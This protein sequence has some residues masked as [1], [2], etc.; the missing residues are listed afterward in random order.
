MKLE[1]DVRRKVIR[2]WM[3]LARDKRRTQ[4]QAAAFAMEA[5]RANAIGRSR[6]D[7]YRR[8]MGWLLPRTGKA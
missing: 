8:I 3:S 1:H 5:I 2:E 6:E 7:P 4:E